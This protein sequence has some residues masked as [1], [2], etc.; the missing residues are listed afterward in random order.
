MSEQATIDG[1]KFKAVIEDNFETSG[2]NIGRTKNTEAVEMAKIDAQSQVPEGFWEKRGGGVKGWADNFREEFE[3]SVQRSHEK[4]LADRDP[5]VRA[6]ADVVNQGNATE[7]AW[8]ASDAAHEAVASDYQRLQ[9]E[10]AAQRE[11]QS[12]E[13]PNQ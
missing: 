2:P 4:V 10:A 9:A 13:Q 12:P 1:S 11:A 6:A 8:Q 5:D 7:E 3:D